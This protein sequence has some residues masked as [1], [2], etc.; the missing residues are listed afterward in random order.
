MNNNLKRFEELMGREWVQTL[1][2]LLSSNYG[3]DILKIIDYFFV[4]RQ[5]GSAIYPSKEK[6]VFMP[7]LMTSPTDIHTI[8]IGESPAYHVASNGVF[9]GV[10]SGYSHSFKDLEKTLQRVYKKPDAELDYTCMS[11]LQQGVLF[12]NHNP[13]HSSFS[14]TVVG[15]FDYLYRN[16][17]S[18]VD[19]LSPRTV[20]VAGSSTRTNHVV[21]SY[22]L[23]RSIEVVEG[24]HLTKIGRDEDILM[25]NLDKAHEKYGQTKIKWFKTS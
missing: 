20:F 10:S 22:N 7:L 18:V 17:I 5:S 3:S 23:P 1:S 9:L 11:Y 4:D 8:I 12:L 16:I 13:F 2:P 14:N 6:N 25:F 21:E 24:S 19:H 15:V